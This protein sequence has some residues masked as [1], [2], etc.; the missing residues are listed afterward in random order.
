MLCKKKWTSG[1]EAAT[2]G[3][4]INKFIALRNSDL[5]FGPIFLHG[6][7]MLVSNMCISRYKYIMIGQSRES[8][9]TMG[10]LPDT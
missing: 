6:V 7:D 8:C 1:G 9:V 4:L 5:T 2:F 10:L 3:T